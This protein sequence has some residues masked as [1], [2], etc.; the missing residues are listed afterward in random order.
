MSLPG[1]EEGKSSTGWHHLHPAMLWF[2]AGRIL[3]RMLVPL[4]IGG[5]AVSSRE[6]GFRTFIIVSAIISAFGFVSSYLSFRYQLTA[7]GIELREGIFTRRKR[8]IALARISHI[9]THQSALARLIGVVR[10][11]IATEGGS[12]REAS[13]TALSL[14]AAEKIRQHVGDVGSVREEERTLYAASLRDRVLVGATTL[15]IGGAVAMGFLVWRYV[16]RL[17]PDE[18]LEPG[19]SP[20]FLSGA[21][22]YF[23]ELF[24]AISASPALIVLSIIVFLLGIWALSIV[25]SIVRWQGFRIIEHGA[26]LH[27]QSG[28]FSRS[29]TV[30]ARDR[31]QAVEV[32]A[33]LVRNLLGYAQIAIVTAGSGSRERARSRVFI[34]LTSLDRASDYLLALWPEVREDVDWQ[35][36]H[37]YYRRQHINRGLL[38]L[39]PL[40][41][42]AYIN[43]VPLYAAMIVPMSTRVLGLA[44]LIWRTAAPSFAATG[45]ALSDGYLHVRRGAVSP[46]RWIVATSSI[47]AVILQQSLMQRRHGVMNVVIDVNGLANNQRIAIPNLPRTQAEKMQME[48]TPR[49]LPALS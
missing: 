26:E 6:G 46:R 11:D 45:F 7:D 27:R 3:R 49:G 29:R 8:H 40:T 2:E 44:W 22:A 48:L 18:S 28:V 36:V 5:F 4:L 35:P 31:I 34:P 19:A 25:V 16:R 21:T 13:F 37:A 12:E 23:D 39:L 20:T 14:S 30:I 42:V 24:V 1:D 32:H 41:I 17:E 10:L 9:S 43:V 47:Q 15:Q 33:S 38:L